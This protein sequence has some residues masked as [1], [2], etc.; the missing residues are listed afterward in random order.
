VLAIGAA[1]LLRHRHVPPAY[2]ERVYSST[3]GVR[4]PYRLWVPPNYDAKQKYPLVIWLHGSDA[5]GTDNLKQ[6]TGYNDAGITS[7]AVVPLSSLPITSRPTRRASSKWST[8][9]GI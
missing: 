7:L 8:C 3:D 2:Q 4:M 5:V 6:I 1:T 9:K